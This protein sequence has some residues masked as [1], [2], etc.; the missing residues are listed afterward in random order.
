[1]LHFARPLE[2]VTDEDKK[3]QGFLGRSDVYRL[4]R[5]LHDLGIDLLP[6]G[7]GGAY[8]ARLFPDHARRPARGAGLLRAAR[9]VRYRRAPGADIQLSAADPD[10]RRLRALWLSDEAARAGGSYRRA[11]LRQRAR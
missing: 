10:Q 6:D 2:E 7:H 4:R 8:G 1:M 3:P 11:R 9:F 5:V